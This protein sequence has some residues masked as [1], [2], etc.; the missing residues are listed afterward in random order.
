MHDYAN[1]NND[2]YEEHVVIWACG[3]IDLD[4]SPC[5]F[6]HDVLV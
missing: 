6:G 2:I 5:F 1:N 3:G 4:V